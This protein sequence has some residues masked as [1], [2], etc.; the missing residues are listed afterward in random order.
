[1]ERTYLDQFIHPLAEKGGIE[2]IKIAGVLKE[3]LST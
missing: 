3:L 2:A 1:M